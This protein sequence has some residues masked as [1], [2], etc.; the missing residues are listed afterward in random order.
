MLIGLADREADLCAR[1][2]HPMAVLKVAHA[3]GAVERMLVTRPSVVVVPATLSGPDAAL[4][5]ER[6]QDIGAA[7]F[8]VMEGIAEADLASPLLEALHHRES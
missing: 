5:K 2:C 3:K 1:I 4:L 8:P 7:F 6:A